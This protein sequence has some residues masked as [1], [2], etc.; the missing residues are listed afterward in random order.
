MNQ[1]KL[2]GQLVKEPYFASK[3]WA[4]VI[5]ALPKEGTTFKTWINLFF[6]EQAAKAL[7]AFDKGDTVTVEGSLEDN[8]DKD[9]NRSIQVPVSR[10]SGGGESRASAPAP[11][12]AW[13][14]GTE[15]GDDDLPPF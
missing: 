6:P 5:I 10:I 4:A 9:G 15:I 11:K 2:Q 13:D 7:K 3:G 12:R 1:V 8:K 14:A